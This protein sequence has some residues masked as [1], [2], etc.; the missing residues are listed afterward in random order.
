MK[1]KTKKLFNRLFSTSKADIMVE[2]R[3]KIEQTNAYLAQRRSYS[4]PQAP[5]GFKPRTTSAYF[6]SNYR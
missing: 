6:F 4:V 1:Q 5:M 3:V 2:K